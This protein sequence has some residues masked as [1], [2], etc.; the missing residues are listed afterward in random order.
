VL[1][2]GTGE[3]IEDLESFHPDRMAGRILGMGD[4]VGLVEKASE[5]IDEREAQDTYEKMVMGTF[6]LED[7]LAQLRMMRRLG[8]MKKVLGMM[9]GVGNMAKDL[10]IDDK[11]MNR[12]EALFTSM[13]PAERLHPATLDMSRRR[14]IARGSGQ[15]V[16]AVNELLKRFK[17][18]KK[19]MK[20]MGK[21]GMGAKLGA[22]AKRE[23]LKGMSDTG[24]LAGDA[25]AGGLGSMFGG[26]GLGSMLGG[27][28]D[29]GGMEAPPGGA[30][31][32]DGVRPMGSS[33]TRKRPPKRK[34]KP[35]K[36]RKGRKR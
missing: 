30:S 7:M 29:G 32:L 17:D 22:K 24:E 25:G 31:P 34:K 20:Q 26:G 3:K 12:L 23:S 15:E 5:E 11:H 36:S 4:V 6:T 33:S 9:P 27:G 21:M 8:P 14:R 13:T 2:V 1:F 28:G 16:G 18:M 19:L 10:D 35:K